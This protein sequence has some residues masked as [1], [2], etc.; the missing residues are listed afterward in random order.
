LPILTSNIG[1]AGYERHLYAA[2]LGK[3]AGSALHCAGSD[4]RT[5]RRP[6]NVEGASM[7][8][9]ERAAITLAPGGFD[10]W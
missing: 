4:L 1:F 6:P 10:G 2:R 5:G 9:Q 7:K 3:I 8:T